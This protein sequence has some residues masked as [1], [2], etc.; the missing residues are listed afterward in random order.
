MKST[1]AEVSEE[2]NN[3]HELSICSRVHLQAEATEDQERMDKVIQR[4]IPCDFGL[5]GVF[6]KGSDIA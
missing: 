3:I 5:L 1:K 4:A 6:M 2:K